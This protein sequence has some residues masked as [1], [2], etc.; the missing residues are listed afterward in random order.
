MELH[1]R[2]VG[3]Q[4]ADNYQNE[5]EKGIKREGRVVTLLLFSKDDWLSY[6]QEMEISEKSISF[7]RKIQIVK[8]FTFSNT[9]LIYEYKYSNP[10]LG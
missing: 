1:H 7:T 6:W 5:V 3:R 4:W 10:S 8:L 9:Q 2:H